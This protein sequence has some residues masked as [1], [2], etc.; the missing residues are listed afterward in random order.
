MERGDIVKPSNVFRRQDEAREGTE[1]E[2]ALKQ[3]ANREHFTAEISTQAGANTYV[4]YRFGKDGPLAR[5]GYGATGEPFE[6][7]WIDGTRYER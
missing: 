7:I 4:G 2:I 5:V 3:I 1:F 6:V